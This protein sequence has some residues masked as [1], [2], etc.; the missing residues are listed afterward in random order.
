MMLPLLLPAVDTT[1]PTAKT[2][3]RAIAAAGPVRYHREERR[4]K[5]EFT[6]SSALDSPTM[7]VK[8]TEKMNALEYRAMSVPPPPLRPT[9]LPKSTASEERTKEEKRG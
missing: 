9:V 3:A 5:K 8:Y 2:V 6:V 1:T 7:N 4:G